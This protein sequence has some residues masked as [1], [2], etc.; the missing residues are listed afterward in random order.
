MTIFGL[1]LFE[2]FVLALVL[3]WFAYSVWRA[4][5]KGTCVDCAEG[6]FC[7]GHCSSR[8]RGRFGRRR[9]QAQAS[10]PA[11][12]GVDQVAEELGRGVH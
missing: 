3:G 10:C 11:M 8:K 4:W 2:V 1:S 7:T 5:S 6:D 12:K 9:K